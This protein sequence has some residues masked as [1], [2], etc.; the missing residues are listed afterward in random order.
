MAW[1][2]KDILSLHLLNPKDSPSRKAYRLP[3]VP[4]SLTQA[5]LPVPKSRSRTGFSGRR[6]AIGRIWE[7]THFLVFSFLDLLLHCC[8]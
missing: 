7:L 1:R 4:F 6:A 3:P 8:L 2:T 5:S